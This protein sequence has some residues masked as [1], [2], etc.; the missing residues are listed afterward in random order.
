[1]RVP[2]REVSARL[3]VQ[4]R[5]IIGQADIN[6]KFAGQMS[7][8]QTVGRNIGREDRNEPRRHGGTERIR[9]RRF[10]NGG[11]SGKAGPVR[12]S[13]ARSEER[14]KRAEAY[15]SFSSETRASEWRQAASAWR[16]SRVSVCFFAPCLRASSEAGGDS[17][18]NRRPTRR[19]K[20]A[21]ARGGHSPLQ[22]QRWKHEIT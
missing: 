19:R 3:L 14:R 9:S 4:A 22:R 6:T 13:L 5:H 1:M 12:R 10:D 18:A 20:V 15:S 17:D 8:Q 21:R 2:A 11:L 7:V 16:H